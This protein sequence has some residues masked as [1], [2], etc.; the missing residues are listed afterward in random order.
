MPVEYQTIF[1]RSAIR[2]DQK[3]T[4]TK[5]YMAWGIKNQSVLL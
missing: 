3:L 2:R 4:G 1:V 5:E